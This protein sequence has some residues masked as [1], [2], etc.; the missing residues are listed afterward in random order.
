MVGKDLGQMEY[1]CTLYPRS[2]PLLSSLWREIKNRKDL[3]QARSA[4]K[5]K[6][7]GK[8]GTLQFSMTLLG[9]TK[10]CPC[11]W[12]RSS[13]LEVAGQRD[14]SQIRYLIDPRQRVRQRCVR[15][16]F[17][18]PWGTGFSGLLA[19]RRH[20]SCGNLVAVGKIP[21]P[22]PTPDSQSQPGP[23][24]LFLAWN[25]VRSCSLSF[26]LQPSDK[27]PTEASLFR[28]AYLLFLLFVR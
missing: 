5:K 28:P 25:L 14:P 10:R 27:D 21:G 8:K 2:V 9:E 19:P 23:G 17:G 6:K 22:L 12:L 18:T 20:P 24:P 13:L 7:E 16:R 3:E 4:A 26:A 1:L 11:A 15:R